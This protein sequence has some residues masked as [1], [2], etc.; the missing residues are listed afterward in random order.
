MY[1]PWNTFNLASQASTSAAMSSF[2]IEQEHQLGHL[3]STYRNYI[4]HYEMAIGKSYISGHFTFNNKLKENFGN[5]YDFITMLR[6]PVKRWISHY[7]FNRYKESE[8]FKNKESIDDIINSELGISRGSM[9]LK[10]LSG[11]SNSP[12]AVQIAKDNIKLF[13]LVGFLE[14]LDDFSE[15]FHQIF[16]KRLKIRKSNTNPLSQSS[17]KSELTDQRLYR[18]EEICKPDIE[19]YRYALSKWI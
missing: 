4:L 15:S 6:D 5:D 17:I 7:Y 19:I 9:M 3:L 12:D 1:C 11:Y 13:T 10:W 14:H 16:G 2:G 18:I 8:H